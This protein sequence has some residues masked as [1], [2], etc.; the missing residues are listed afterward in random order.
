MSHL[1]DLIKGLQ[2]TPTE[3]EQIIVSAVKERQ[4]KVRLDHRRQCLHFG[5]AEMEGDSMRYQLQTL[6]TQLARVSALHL[7]PPDPQARE[8]AR[9]D[10]MRKVLATME[11]QHL[12]TLARK[13]A[14]EKQK[15]DKERE[16]QRRREQEQLRKV[17][18]E[19]R[20]R[21]HE[22]KRMEEEKRKREEE[23]KKKDEEALAL[24]TVQSK[25]KDVS[26]HTHTHTETHIDIYTSTNLSL[27]LSL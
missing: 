7:S 19:K 24:E 9:A 4:V 10:F 1:K 26:I 8:A 23:K 15:V 16:R 27:S 21:E 22:E 12:A 3:I 18:E 6:A 13:D 20:R 5:E 25:L 17:E 2:I 14:I 11:A